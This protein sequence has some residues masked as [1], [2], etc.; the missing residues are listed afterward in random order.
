MSTSQVAG[1]NE[2]DACGK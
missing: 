1:Y 2:N